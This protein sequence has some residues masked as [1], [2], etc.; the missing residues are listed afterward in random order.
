MF[1]QALNMPSLDYFLFDKTIIAFIW[2]DY[3]IVNPREVVFLRAWQLS[4]FT[5]YE[6]SN[7]ILSYYMYWKINF[8]KANFIILSLCHIQLRLKSIRENKISDVNEFELLLFAPLKYT[9]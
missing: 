9:R 2:G 8:V 4:V 1:W 5:S 6:G 3:Q 7:F